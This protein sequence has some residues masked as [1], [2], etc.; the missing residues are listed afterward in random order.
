[1]DGTQSVQLFAQ[2]DGYIGGNTA[3]QV[4]DAEKLTITLDQSS[5]REDAG[6]SA[7]L[8]TLSRSNTDTLLP[9]SIQLTNSDASEA[10]IPVSI[11]IPSGTQSVSFPL[12]A[13]DDT[14]LDGS[15]SVTLAGSANGY[16]SASATLV[17]TDAE[18]VSIRLNKSSVSENAGDN[19]VFATV[20]L[21]TTDR[22]VATLVQL[23]SSDTTELTV[24]ASIFIPANVLSVVVPVSVGDDDL[25]DGTQQVIVQATSTNYLDGSGSIAI[26]DWETLSVQLSQ[27]RVP[28]TVGKTSASVSRSNSDTSKPLTVTL[29]G[30]GSTQVEVPNQVTI[31]AGQSSVLFDISIQDN[32]LVTGDFVETIRV[33]GQGYVDGSTDLTVMDQ[34]SLQMSLDTPKVDER[35]GSAKLSITRLNSNVDQPLT[36]F[37]SAN[38]DREV[39]LP[40]QVTIPSGESSIDVLVR[41]HDDFLFDGDITT[42]ITVSALNYVSVAA[43]IVVVD[44]DIKTPGTNPKNPYDVDNDGSVSPLDVLVIINRINTN[45][46]SQPIQEGGYYYDV[47]KDL[48]VS[49]I[50]VLSIINYLN[51]NPSGSE[52][53]YFQVD[54]SERWRKQL[55]LVIHPSILVL[56]GPQQ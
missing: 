17:V 34:E 30:Q 55:R 11:T 44:D 7:T 42:I 54:S 18:F 21:T 5:I 39:D 31:P 10:R 48:G 32:D 27:A 29:I 26:D 33:S 35:N 52:G 2:A 36:L 15:Q 49:P 28:E 20:E 40:S 3:I 4:T 51:E 46:S 14:L 47:D 25:L 6:N 41:G 43:N 45:R 22:T 12:D 8:A 9:L 24:P 53:E 50:D 37:I 38:P 56:S 19:S 23:T 16:V 1:L 13:I